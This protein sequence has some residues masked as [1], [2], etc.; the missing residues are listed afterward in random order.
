MIAGSILLGRALAPV[1]QAIGGWPLVLR[2]RQGWANLKT[3]LA[4]TPGAEPTRP[5]CPARAPIS[6]S[7]SS[8]WCRRSSRR[9]ACGCSTSSSSPGQ[10]L[11]VI[12][13]SASGKSTLARALTGIWRPA[14]GAVRLDGAALLALRARRAR[15]LHRLPAAGRG[16]VRR[17]A[18]PRTSP[19]MQTSP[20][21]AKVVAAAKKAGAHEMILD[22]PQGYDTPR[23]R[24]R[25]AAL[26]R[27]EAAHRAGAR[28]LRRAGADGARR[29]QLQPRRRRPGRAQRGDPPGQGRGQGG[30]HHGAPPGRHRR[31]RHHPHHRR[32]RRQG[33]RAARRG[34]EGARAQLRP[35]RR[36]AS[37]ARRRRHDRA[38]STADRWR[39]AAARRCSAMLTLF[40]LVFGIGAW[41]AV[42]QH[43][44]RGGGRRARSRWRATARSCSTRPAA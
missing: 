22:L 30:G 39:A 18:S 5:P 4:D 26:G 13:A 41:A 28:L 36:A 15:Q 23:L 8:P 25:R 19:G 20:N 6:R 32:R 1:E 21:P 40:L 33:L 42:T 44:R 43:R 7:T 37:A 34:A 3:L 38:A 10:A 31:V 14:A 24:R 2:A 12:G 17:H 35:G 27:A 11:G 16:A 29:A 9:R